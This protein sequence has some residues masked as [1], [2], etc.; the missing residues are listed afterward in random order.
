MAKVRVRGNI[1]PDFHFK[2]C[3]LEF[4]PTSRRGLAG[5]VLTTHDVVPG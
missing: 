4:C 2:A 5:L 1:I 3:G